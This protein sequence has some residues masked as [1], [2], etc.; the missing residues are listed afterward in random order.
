MYRE[1]LQSKARAFCDNPMNGTATQHYGSW[2]SM[3][4]LN[5]KNLVIRQSNPAKYSLTDAGAELALALYEQRA[6]GDSSNDDDPGPSNPRNVKKSRKGTATATEAHGIADDGPSL[7]DM[8]NNINNVEKNSDLFNTEKLKNSL[9]LNLP[10]T[11]KFESESRDDGLTDEER[12]LIAESERKEE[13][14]R[15]VALRRNQPSPIGDDILRQIAEL[16]RLDKEK[17]RLIVDN[18]VRQSEEMDESNLNRDQS[19]SMEDINRQIAELEKSDREKKNFDT[20]GDWSPPREPTTSSALK[21]QNNVSK[22]TTKHARDLVTQ[23]ERDV[24]VISVPDS[25]D[26]V[27]EYNAS[28]ST[29]SY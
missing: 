13:E 28:V 14:R 6:F 1:D 2:N 10:S 15:R 8:L 5:R 23:N 16:D 25:D 17:K 29:L 7:D 12:R 24:E 11:S 21:S 4:T 3:G 19:S 27:F 18:V 9:D 22:S 20:T 26:E